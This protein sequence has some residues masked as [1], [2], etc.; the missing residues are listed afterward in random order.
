MLR[1]ALK[2]ETKIAK[3]MEDHRHGWTFLTNHMHVLVVL[4]R[5]PELRIRDMADQIGITQRAVQ[6]ILAELIEAGV[7]KATRHGRRN[8]YTIRRSTRLRHPLE[9]KHTVGELIDLLG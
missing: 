4:A 7:L 5:D 3:S 2:P 1:A 6:R 8:R 9:S